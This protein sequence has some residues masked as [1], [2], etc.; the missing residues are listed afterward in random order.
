VSELRAAL[1]K[2][3][4]STD[5]LKQDLINR[6]QARLDEEEF[7]ME[8]MGIASGT[9]AVGN[10]ESAPTPSKPEIEEDKSRTSASETISKSKDTNKTAAP[11]KQKQK[12]V[13]NTIIAKT[14]STTKNDEPK[15]KIGH[16]SQTSSKSF[17]EQKKS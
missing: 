13:D 10:K 2:R 3:G 11:V 6:L 17:E 1:E 12:S 5:G 9:S 7:G 14:A 16:I 15:A 8:D 4:L